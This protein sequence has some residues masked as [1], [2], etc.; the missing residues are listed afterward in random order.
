M[1][2]VNLKF[3]GGANSPLALKIRSVF[4]NDVTVARAFEAV[5]P[6]WEDFTEAV[7]SG[8][9]AGIVDSVNRLLAAQNETYSTASNLV[10]RT[11]TE[12]LFRAQDVAN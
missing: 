9:Q 1:N 8:D 10:I 6:I 5:P 7:R 12:E 11:L 4:E 2:R 3:E